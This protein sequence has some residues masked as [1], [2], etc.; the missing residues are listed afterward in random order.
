ML[1]ETDKTWL[2]P[3]SCSLLSPHSPSHILHRS[4]RIF[5]KCYSV[6]SLHYFKFS[7]AF[8]SIYNKIQIS[9]RLPV[10]CP[11]QPP[12]L[13]YSCQKQCFVFWPSQCSSKVQLCPQDTNVELSS[14]Q[15][16][17]GLLFPPSG[18]MLLPERSWLKSRPSPAG[19]GELMF[20]VKQGSNRSVLYFTKIT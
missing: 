18:Q 20:A 13:P 4:Q 19:D 2:L 10:L 11:S 16:L 7:M 12:F 15:L 5:T 3:I 8:S 14:P 9:S 17:T 1:T 6:L